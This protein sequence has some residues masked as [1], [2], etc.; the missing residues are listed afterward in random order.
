LK[1]LFSEN[2]TAG[3]VAVVI[4]CE[5]SSSRT[6]RQDEREETKQRVG[7]VEGAEGRSRCRCGSMRLGFGCAVAFS[8]RHVPSRR[9]HPP[10]ASLSLFF[11]AASGNPTSTERGER[12]PHCS[13]LLA[14]VALLYPPQPICSLHHHPTL[15]RPTSTPFRTFFL[16]AIF[17]KK[18]RPR[19]GRPPAPA[20]PCL[21][22]PPL[23]RLVRVVSP[24]AGIGGGR[25]RRHRREALGCRSGSAPCSRDR[26]TPR[27]RRR[28][29]VVNPEHDA[30]PPSSK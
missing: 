2:V 24:E 11:H 10:P 30:V 7:P 19:I 16:Q 15:P 25:R 8:H 23:P 1:H 27:A 21:P 14:H 26:D 4:P 20:P 6:P 12:P 3:I 18:P 29:A 22:P 13:A 17:K 9:H 28:P 5:R